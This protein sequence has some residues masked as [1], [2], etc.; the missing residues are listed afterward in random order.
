[1]MMNGM[2]NLQVYASAYNVLRI[3]SGI[4]A[5]YPYDDYPIP[6]APKRPYGYWTIRNHFIFL[7]TTR[8]E[9]YQWL[10]ITNRLDIFP[11]EIIHQICAFIATE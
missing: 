5:R 4:G 11:R 3:M 10:L 7:K 1:M 8:V 9:I 6:E 2:R